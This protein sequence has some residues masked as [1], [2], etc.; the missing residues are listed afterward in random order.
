MT[1]EAIL[2]SDGTN[3]SV[4][5]PESRQAINEVKDRLRSGDRQGVNNDTDSAIRRADKSLGG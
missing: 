5:S 2:H 3:F 4:V 1:L